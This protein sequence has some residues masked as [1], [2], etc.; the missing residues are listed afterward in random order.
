MVNYDAQMNAAVKKFQTDNKLKVSGDIDGETSYQ[1]MD[2]LRE[3]ILE[4]DPQLLK[5]QEVVTDLLNK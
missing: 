4:E 2:L 5:A 3:K 1:L